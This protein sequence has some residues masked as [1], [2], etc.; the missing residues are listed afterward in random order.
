MSIG[1]LLL[2]GVAA[3]VAFMMY[4]VGRGSREV[5]HTHVPGIPNIEEQ[6]A[7]E[8][9]GPSAHGEGSGGESRKR[10]RCC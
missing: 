4:R 7:V 2:I 10:H 9:G 6:R 8:D 3:L 5:A 1:T